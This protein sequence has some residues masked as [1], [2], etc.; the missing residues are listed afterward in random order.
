MAADTEE[1]ST[2]HTFVYLVDFPKQLRKRV[3]KLRDLISDESDELLDNDSDEGPLA[4]VFSAREQAE[5]AAN[6]PS[7]WAALVRVEE[8]Y[9]A[10][11]EATMRLDVSQEALDAHVAVIGYEAEQDGDE[12]DDGDDEGDDGDDDPDADLD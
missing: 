11:G 5:L 7:L 1:L 6:A 10:L 3:E 8:D 4:L 12:D 2:N 9:Q